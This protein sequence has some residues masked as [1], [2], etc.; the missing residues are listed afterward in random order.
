MEAQAQATPVQALGDLPSPPTEIN[1]SPERVSHRVDEWMEMQVEGRSRMAGVGVSMDDPDVRIA[2]EALGDLRADFI[3]PARRQS[4]P[5]TR[6]AV[7]RGRETPGASG[8]R[9]GQEPLL[10]LLATSHPIIGTAVTGSISAYSASKSYSP[11]FKYGAEFVERHF[12]SPVA[13]T[14]GSVGRRTGVEGGVRWW[15]GSRRPG[16]ARRV[17]AMDDE[18]VASKRRR[19]EDRAVKREDADAERGTQ[20]LFSASLPAYSER[21]LSEASFAESLPAYDNNRSPSYEAHGAL[22]S[23][24]R[25]REMAQEQSSNPTWQSRLMLST[26]GLGVAM[27]EESL[28][29]L[30]YCLAWLRWANSHLGKVVVALRDLVAQWEDSSR[31][32]QRR[33]QDAEQHRRNRALSAQSG[34]MDIDTEQQR[35]RQDPTNVGSLVAVSQDH[36]HDRDQERLVEGIHALKSDVLNTLKKVVDVV[37]TYAG[38]ALPEH[39]RSLVRH[40]LTSLP[41]KFQVATASNAGTANGNRES[42][43]LPASNPA[44]AAISSAQRIIVLAKEGLDMMAQVSGVVDGTIASAEDWCDRLGRRKREQSEYYDEMGEREHTAGGHAFSSPDNKDVVMPSLKQE[45]LDY[46]LPVIKKE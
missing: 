3:S 26:S 18:E 35:Q 13:S 20:R 45:T 15:L 38:G 14:V 12:G 29:S 16:Q 36:E 39:A 34:E 23:T 32:A 33:R 8:G 46:T 41:Q 42:S 31:R 25:N 9:Q 22:I 27:S 30:K 19:L 44:S 28:R 2:A 40:S 1:P 11:R 7:Y 37:S 17:S 43:L 5:T 4:S 21:R 10:S 24:Q 6:P